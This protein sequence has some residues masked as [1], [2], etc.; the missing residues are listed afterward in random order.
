VNGIV[1]C[2]S[3]F[4]YAEKPVSF[5]FAEQ[6]HQVT[7]ILSESK[8]EEGYRFLVL[9]G[10][11]EIFQLLYDEYQ[12]QWSVRPIDKIKESTCARHIFPPV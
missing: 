2:T 1:Q 12:E 6:T 8:S 10:Q 7:R 9:T 3:G 11:D 4:R 5:Q